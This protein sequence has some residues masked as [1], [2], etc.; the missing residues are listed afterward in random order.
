MK[1]AVVLVLALFGRCF[2]QTS[3]SDVLFAGNLAGTNTVSRTAD[4]IESN[5]SIEIGAQKIESRLTVRFKDRKPIEI[6][7]VETI[8]GKQGEYLWKNG[9]LTV[10]HG[11]KKDF[12]NRPFEL[13]TS[14]LFSTYHFI[15][16]E[17]IFEQFQRAGKPRTMKALD[18]SSLTEFELEPSVS[19]VTVEIDHKPV[20]IEMFKTSI[21][22]IEL[23]YAFR[24][25]VVVGFKVPAQMFEI[26]ETDARG[27]FVDP[28]AKYP[29][30]SQPVFKVKKIERARTL[31]RDGTVLVSEI[32]MPDAEGKF[33]TV[34]I[35]TPYGRAEM[36]AAY[37]WFAKRGYVVVSQDVR[38]RGGSGGDWDPFNHEVADGYDTL[39]WIASQPWSNGSVGMIGGSYL[40]FVQ[41]AA[42]V[43]HHPALKCIIPQ[44]S[45]P[46]PINNVPWDHGCFFL[47]GNVWWSRIVMNRNANMAAATQGFSSLSAFTAMPLTK[48]DDKLFGKSIPFFDKWTTMTRIEDWPGAFRES[49]V[50][51]VH[52][53]VL[54]VSGVW[55][56]DGV[57]TMMHYEAL[58]RSGGNQWLVFGPWEHAF[59]TR[60]K[61][62][63]VDYGPNAILELDSMYLRFFDTFLKDKQVNLQAMPRVRFFIS[64]MNA[65]Y[66]GD[67]WPPRGTKQ[68]T[69]YLNGG[70]ANGGKSSG[71]LTSWAPHEGA[72]RYDYDPRKVKIPASLDID[73]SAASLSSK[74][75][76]F[77]KDSLLY[78]SEPFKN[79]TIVAG[80]LTVK[81]EFKTTARDAAVHALVFDRAP[82]GKAMIVCG[83]GNMRVGFS[84]NGIQKLKPGKVYSMKIEPW[85]FA[86]EFKPGHRLLIVITSDRFPEYARIPGTGDPDDRAVKMIRA[87]H[88]VL[89]GAKTFVQYYLFDRQLVRR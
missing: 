48:V 62:G 54:H 78:S 5:T 58:Q 61:Y 18:L 21:K 35:R 28:L 85:L 47:L 83:P 38:G 88:T 37:E 74:V 77:G 33:P 66:E 67:A 57:G 25:G 29:E 9:R 31:M 23:Q 27:V 14:A 22:G 76:E 60:S 49:Q 87:T 24:N 41:W 17:T 46:D 20:P 36:A 82:N 19:E 4:G 84:S 34:L 32:R 55:D 11:G 42:A 13:K 39:S 8:N 81:L 15:T 68:I 79:P 50:G 63:D 59:N 65:W 75:S 53:P 89:R 69:M 52:I 44:V 26:V 72:D 3:Q 71:T 10:S 45:P 7:L 70:K 43:T 56:G 64:G 6:A 40:G 30:L 80:P 73:S 51:S 1:P 16:A 2:A 86:H 12:E